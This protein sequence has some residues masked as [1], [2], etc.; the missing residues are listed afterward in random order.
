MFRSR[1]LPRAIGV[2]LSLA[3][4]CY[5]TNSLLTFA[6][7]ALDAKIYPAIL[8]ACFPGEFLSSLWMA[9]VGLNAAKWRRWISPG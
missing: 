9:T 4:F 3:G 5:V 1:F 2:L 6:A 7:P 8:F